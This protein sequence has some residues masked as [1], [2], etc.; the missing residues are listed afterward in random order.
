MNLFGRI[1]LDCLL[2]TALSIPLTGKGQPVWVS[3]QGQLRVIPSTAYYEG[4]LLKYYNLLP[5]YKPNA[6]SV[7][8]TRYGLW[9][10][11]GEMKRNSDISGT[12]IIYDRKGNIKTVLSASSGAHSI[13]MISLLYEKQRI[14]EIIDSTIDTD[15][16][17]E[18]VAEKMAEPNLFLAKFP[19]GD[20]VCKAKKY[21]TTLTDDNRFEFNILD[22]QDVLDSISIERCVT[23]RTTFFK[24]KYDSKGF[25]ESAMRRNDNVPWYNTLYVKYK[26]DGK[27]NIIGVEEFDDA[28]KRKTDQWSFRYDTKN[29]M[30]AYQNTSR[31]YHWNYDKYGRL[32]S[33]R[34]TTY[35][36][37]NGGRGKKAYEYEY[38]FEFGEDGNPIRCVCYNHGDISIIEGGHE[39]EY[40]YTYYPS[41]K[42][43]KT[44]TEEQKSQSSKLQE[45]Q[46]RMHDSIQR[47]YQRRMDSVKLEKQK[48]ERL[49]QERQKEMLLPCRFLFSSNGAFESCVVK[50]NVIAEK[51]IMGLIVKK[52]QFVYSQT[53]NG[54]EIRKP[55]NPARNE[56]IQ[57][58][59][60]CI[61]L[62]NMRTEHNGPNGEIVEHIYNYTESKLGEFV[63]GRSTLNKAYKKSPNKEYS[64]FLLSYMNGK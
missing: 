36:Y 56:L 27:G 33:Y 21:G 42:E 3:G 11:F 45:K 19:N 10:D 23:K 35:S 7:T 5:Q 43:Q 13:S 26:L 41:P 48:Q 64:L 63:I 17:L 51:E 60:M 22:F 1:V 59:N 2:L 31:D 57:I 20:A 14:V 25:L 40:A 50:Q 61:Q 24:Y 54:K 38:K 4:G 12:K 30:I 46:T 32:V 44:Q 29:R 28:N 18:K 8:I 39:Y 16:V 49:R 55:D 58:C 9:N 52:I 62:K 6:K 15:K 37:S 34:E 47:D 53:V